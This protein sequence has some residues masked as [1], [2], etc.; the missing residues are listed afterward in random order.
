MSSSLGKCGIFSAGE[1]HVT[2][3]H[4]VTH[5]Y[6]FHPI[7]SLAFWHPHLQRM[8]AAC[9]QL[10]HFPA[11]YLLCPT[12]PPS[13]SLHPWFWQTGWIEVESIDMLLLRTSFQTY[14]PSFLHIRFCFYFQLAC[15]MRADKK[16]DNSLNM[17]RSIHKVFRY[18]FCA[19]QEFRIV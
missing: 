8:H 14:L 16:I 2:N 10:H 18:C 19:V 7:P 3:E 6:I 1:K 5:L 13:A 4:H 17:C 15:G 11:M 12:V 9:A